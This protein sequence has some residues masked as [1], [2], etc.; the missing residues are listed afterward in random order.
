MMAGNAAHKGMLVHMAEETAF[1]AAT[2][3]RETP[4]EYERSRRLFV[5]AD[6][7]NYTNLR[8][9]AEKA[10]R[11]AMDATGEYGV[12]FHLAQGQIYVL[13]ANLEYALTEFEIASAIDDSIEFV[14]IN[15][16]LTYRKLAGR[17]RSTNALDKADEMMAESIA[18]LERATE[19]SPESPGAWSTKAMTYLATGDARLTD[20]EGCTKQALSLDPN[21]YSALTSL[22]QIRQLHGQREEARELALQAI[23]LKPNNFFAYSLLGARKGSA[24]LEP[25]PRKALAWLQMAAER[26]PDNT[27]VLGEIAKTYREL[28]DFPHAL[29][30]FDKVVR[31]NPESYAS[32]ANRGHA[33]L[34]LKQYESAET[35][36]RLALSIRTDHV[37]ALSALRDLHRELGRNEDALALAE[38]AL[39]WNDNPQQRKSHQELVE[40]VQ[41][42]HSESIRATRQIIDSRSDLRHASTMEAATRALHLFSRNF[43]AL[44]LLGRCN[45]ALGNY[46]LARDYLQRALIVN[47]TAHFY[48]WPLGQVYE[49]LKEYE[50]ALREFR[51]YV[52]R[53][54]Q[55]KGAQDAIRRVQDKLRAATRAQKQIRSE[56]ELVFLNNKTGREERHSISL[57]REFLEDRIRDWDLPIGEIIEQVGESPVFIIAK[58]GVGKTVTVP[59]KILLSLCDGLVRSGNGFLREVPQVFV[60][61]PRIPIC[62][63]TMAE[64]NEGYQ[65]YLAYRLTDNQDVR[66]YIAS[67]GGEIGPRDPK[68]MANI[69]RLVYELV[70]AGKTQYDPRHFNLYGCITSATGKI[71][72]DAPI[73]FVTTGIMESLTFEGTK[74]N[75]R[76]NRIVIDEAHVTIEANP[77]IELGIALARKQG[78]KIDYMSATVEPGN[79]AEDLGVTVVYAGTQRFPIHLTNLGTTVEDRILDLVNDFLLDPDPEKFPRPEDFGDPV[80]RARIQRIRLHLLSSQGFDDEG[81]HYP[82]LSERPQGMLLICT[83]N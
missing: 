41:N 43:H 75:P 39:R 69:V 23:A 52:A 36:L 77:A 40:L 20:A 67:R 76:L 57:I 60:V 78:V 71:N 7:L 2:V 19:V 70:E 54:T 32:L 38:Q 66:D 22:A 4:E 24:A 33:H 11:A 73:V 18:S 26:Y 49:E 35:D 3:R 48:R 13:H 27:F 83:E 80:V 44:G 58:T 17:L 47:P 29:E 12:F 72:A 10:Y 64:M 53:N 59:T 28:Q 25:K 1:D 21:S 62:T 55:N 5:E 56:Q 14:H 30:Y 42:D 68:S 9:E 61:E 46:P 8:D 74:L 79:L 51:L 45:V 34:K 65:S 37:P 15:L 31:A 16:G 82:G 6:T 50:A 63:M 81:R